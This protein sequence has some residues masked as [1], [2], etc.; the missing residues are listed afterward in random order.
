MPAPIALIEQ[1]TLALQTDSALVG[2]ALGERI[3]RLFYSDLQRILAEEFAPFAAEGSSL[4]LPRLVLE[5]EP[6]AAGHLEQELPERLRAALRKALAAVPRPAGG[7]PGASAAPLA[8]LRYFLVSGRLPWAAYAPDFDL[9][10]VVLRALRAQRGAL[11]DLLRQVGGQALA[12]QR[13][14]RQLT[15]E[16]LARLIAFLEPGQAD[17]VLAF[18]RE[19]MAQ[20]SRRP[21][22]PASESA[23]RYAVLEQVVASL[24]STQHSLFDSLA[25]VEQQ[26]RQ[27]AARYG[28]GYA[29]VV[30]WQQQGLA[31]A[32]VAASSAAFSRIIRALQQQN[33]P[34]APDGLAEL[35]APPSYSLGAVEENTALA[36]TYPGPAETT[37]PVLPPIAA[38]M[39]LGRKLGPRPAAFRPASQF[40]LAA[41][42]TPSEAR[43][44]IFSY[45][46]SGEDGKAPRAWLRANLW[47]AATQQPAAVA[48]FLHRY[49]SQPGVLSRLV[50]VADFATLELL[51]RRARPTHRPNLAA[52]DAWAARQ[53]G[54]QRMPTFLKALF[55]AFHYPTTGRLSGAAIRQLAAAYHL[56]W[57]AALTQLAT[58]R[59]HWPALAAAPFFLRVWALL[60]PS[61]TSAKQSD[62]QPKPDSL[63][64]SSATRFQPEESA[65]AQMALVLRY[66]LQAPA[67]EFSQSLTM[68]RQAFQQAIRQPSSLRHFLRQ[69]GGQAAVQQR[70]AH[71]ADFGSLHLLVAVPGAGRRPRQQ[72]RQ[73]LAAL[74]RHLHQSTRPGPT[75][76]GLFLR[77]A[78]S[79]Y[80]LTA[81]AGQPATSAKLLDDIRQ[82]ATGAGLAWHS[83]LTR[84]SGLLRQIPVLAADLFFHTLLQAVVEQPTRPRRRLAGRAATKPASL[85][86]LFSDP[87]QSA[88]D[89]WNNLEQHLQ[90]GDAPLTGPL[91]QAVTELLSSGSASQFERLRPY[92]ALPMARARL[93]AVLTQ[94]QFT[95]LLLALMPA[96]YRPLAALLRD[97]QRLHQQR[98]VQTSTGSVLLWA[99]VLAVAA[100][101]GASTGE[102]AAAL[103][104]SLMRLEQAHLSPAQRPAPRRL[105]QAITQ[106]GLALRS[107]LAALLAALP[108]AVVQPPQQAAPLPAAPELRKASLSKLPTAER[109]LT[110]AVYVAN[111]GLVL[112]YPFFTLLFERVGLLQEKAFRDPLAAE[113]AAHLLQFLVTG[114]ED[115]PEYLLVLNKLLCGI[116]RPQPL[117]RIVPLTAEEKATAEGLLGA[118]L[119][120]WQA[121]KNTSIAGL[122]ETFLQRPGKLVWSPDKVTLTVET[123]TVDILLDQLPWSITLIKLPWMALP[124]YVTWR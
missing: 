76:F 100:F 49:G 35:L 84:L 60:P 67:D 118:A 93:A 73:A 50:Q 70:L 86:R 104:Q 37:S 7:A 42:A 116:E 17:V 65:Q 115:F 120:R 103:V 119:G 28:L 82:R 99:E 53:A 80:A 32:P 79:A 47:R 45:L 48:G 69:H 81:V 10:A 94:K 30:Q 71:L 44:L 41:P 23:L 3:S 95:D 58:L 29:A 109:P 55:V 88:E 89:T 6:V 43:E 46:L 78:Y 38:A 20:Q 11:R 112:L 34:V 106:R 56:P 40:Y 62:R 12:R 77:E 108:G 68:L 33:A 96:A 52:L 31:S 39:A 16:T 21:L 83:V 63:F 97:W 74:D 24:T 117:A 8:T 85:P 19:V 14:V 122:R 61:Q 123:K 15:P 124:L 64:E 92:L 13:L 59:S 26:L 27:L 4:R 101:P 114:G 1:L 22:M 2:K 87:T 54:E 107:P 18:V 102:R 66:L 5:L 111:A 113:R 98:L 57:D 9:D 36:V 25:F 72:V 90:S 110:E 91:M 51:P 75:R 121:L 105:V